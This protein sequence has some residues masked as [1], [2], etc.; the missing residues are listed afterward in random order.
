MT[1][2]NTDANLAG[3]RRPLMFKTRAILRGILVVIAAIAVSASA[4]YSQEIKS[5][6][7]AVGPAIARLTET[8]L[9]SLFPGAKVQWDPVLTI[10]EGSGPNEPVDLGDFTAHRLDDGSTGGVAMLEVGSAKAEH[11]KKLKKFQSADGAQFETTIVAFRIP[12]SGSGMEIKK[13]PLDPYDRLTK[14][15]WFEV[16]KWLPGGWPVLHLRYE[17]YSTA[18]DSVTILEWDSL[19]NMATGSFAGRIPEG[20]SVL[21]PGGEETLETFSVHRTSA[22]QIAIYDNGTGKTID[23]PCG[24]PCVVD[25]RTF[26][27][28]LSGQQ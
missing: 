8:L 18:G 12:P 3:G 17:S 5:R 28:Q 22:T 4:A 11:I 25:G 23:Y 9:H 26:L 14:I 27:G 2:Q 20:M 24:D 19:V 7:D 1:K 15:N 13:I 21:H 10:R 16:Q 6:R